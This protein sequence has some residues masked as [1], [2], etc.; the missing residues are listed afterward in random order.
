MSLTTVPDFC[1]LNFCSEDGGVKGGLYRDSG[2]RSGSAAKSGDF[3]ESSGVDFAGPHTQ[4][5]SQF[6]HLFSSFGYRVVARIHTSSPF[7]YNCLHQF[8]GIFGVITSS[9]WISGLLILPVPRITALRS[10]VL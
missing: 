1:V 9:I 6:N 8:L 4:M 5:Y 10:S 7:V 2:F 3:A